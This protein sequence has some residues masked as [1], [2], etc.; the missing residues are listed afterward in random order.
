M[1]CRVDTRID[2]VRGLL[3]PHYMKLMQF[4]PY[5]RASNTN[6]TPTGE[7]LL[8]RGGGE[9]TGTDHD[10]RNYCKEPDTDSQ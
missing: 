1:L 5:L 9:K 4:L 3:M 10:G 6:V 2:L 8:D 7:T